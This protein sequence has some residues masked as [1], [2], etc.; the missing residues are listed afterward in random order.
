MAGQPP[1]LHHNH[2][3]QERKLVR[4]AAEATS[5]NSALAVA[6]HSARAAVQQTTADSV[7]AFD[8][9]SPPLY[10]NHQLQ[11]HKIDDYDVYYYV[12]SV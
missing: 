10:H 3:L 8:C 12:T 5:A 4:N 7:L 1:P 6:S 9:Q 2:Q 11:E